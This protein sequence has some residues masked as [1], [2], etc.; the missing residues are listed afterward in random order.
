MARKSAIAAMATAAVAALVVAVAIG[1]WWLAP[2]PRFSMPRTVAIREGEPFRAVARAL[3]DAGVVKSATATLLYGEF[4][5]AARHV[6]PGEYQF[7]GGETVAEVMHH[8]VAGNVVS[9]TV[10]IP[11]GLTLHQIAERLSAAGL[12]C[13]PEF[14]REARGGALVRALGL[15]PLGAEGFLFPAT[16]KFSPHATVNQ[17]LQAMLER[18]YRTLTPQVERRMFALGLDD[19]GLVT[20][21][22]IVEKEA[23]VPGE[24]PLIAGVF[25]NRLRIGMPLQSDPTAEYSLDGPPRSAVAA[26]HADGEFNTY[27]HP[28]LPPGPIA[29]PGLSSLKAALYPARTDF[30]YF[31]ARPDGTHVFSRS[32]AQ[33]KRAIAMIRD[34]AARTPPQP[35]AAHHGH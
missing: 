26:V 34:A 2:P 11:E 16:Y 20:M 12:V 31:V 29:D 3:A 21:A 33:H 22:S 30:L 18:F 32:F 25:Y 4:T 13:Q 17:I 28:G 1:Y 15:G 19:R 6:K 9:V 23:R 10:V 35:L 5:G 24:R 7:R 8:L 27:V 14:A